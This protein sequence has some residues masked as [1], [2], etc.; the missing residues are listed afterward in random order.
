MDFTHPMLQIPQ[1]AEK[2]NAQKYSDNDQTDD[3]C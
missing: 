1:E 3:T 2:K